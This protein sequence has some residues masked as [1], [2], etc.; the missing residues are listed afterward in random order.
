MTGGALRKVDY[1]AGVTYRKSG[2]AFADILPEDDWFEQTAF[3][4]GLG[5]TLGSRASLRT[6]LRYSRAN[7]RR[8]ARSPT[9]PGIPAGST[10]RTI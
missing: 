4:G 5:G 7:G 9:D 3:D 10:T 6:S 2:G 8:W 1:Q